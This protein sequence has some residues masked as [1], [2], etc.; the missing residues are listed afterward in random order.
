MKIVKKSAQLNLRHHRNC[1]I[2]AAKV[3][4]GQVNKYEFGGIVIGSPSGE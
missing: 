3:A 2:G 4:L 1:A